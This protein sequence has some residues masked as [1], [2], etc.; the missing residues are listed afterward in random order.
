LYD[1]IKSVIIKDINGTPILVKNV[2]EVYESNNP[3]LGIVARG[4]EPDVVEG[5]VLMRKGIDP[6]PV[7]KALEK[8]V[9]ELDEKVLPSDVNMLTV[10]D[11]QNLIDFCLHTVF[12]NVLE[13]IF[14]VTLIVFFI[15][16]RLEG[17]FNSFP[18]HSAVPALCIYHVYT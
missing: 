5:I 15:Y 3:R 7:L 10:Y 9:K 17:H 1:D 4:H 13:G 18:D 6:G 12:H 11:R 16:A 8:E 2:A 14:L